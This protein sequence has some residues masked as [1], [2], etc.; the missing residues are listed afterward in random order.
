MAGAEGNVILLT[1]RGEDGT[2][3]RKLFDDWESFQQDDRRYGTGKIGVIG[4]IE[5]QIDVEVS[6]SIVDRTILAAD[7][8]DEL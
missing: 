2:L 3:T 7:N 4:K 6:L 8:L 1:S 5:Q